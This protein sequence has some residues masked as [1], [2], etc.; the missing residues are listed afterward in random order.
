M[1]VACR[2]GSHLRVWAS[3]LLTRAGHKRCYLQSRLMRRCPLCGASGARV[4]AVSLNPTTRFIEDNIVLCPARWRRCHADC[5]HRPPVARG[6]RR[7][8]VIAP[9][10]PAS[11]PPVPHLRQH[12]QREANLAPGK[13]ADA[14]EKNQWMNQMWSAKCRQAAIRK[15]LKEKS[16]GFGLPF[17]K[18]LDELRN[19]VLLVTGKLAGLIK[20]LP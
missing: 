4:S 3:A 18:C 2:C 10:C 20:N 16:G 14:P 8:A 15:Q 13:G 17:D 5:T 7:V 11:C 9:A 12:S 6:S 1:L 19:F